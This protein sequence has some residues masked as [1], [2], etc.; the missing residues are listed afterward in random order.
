MRY[1]MWK[2]QIPGYSQEVWSSDIY[3]QSLILVW[4]QKTVLSYKVSKKRP[5]QKTQRPLW[6]GRVVQTPQSEMEMA[7]VRPHSRELVFFCEFPTCED[8]SQ[9]TLSASLQ[10][11]GRELCMLQIFKNIKLILLFNSIVCGVKLIKCGNKPR[12]IN[13]M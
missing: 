12:W 2:W 4:V 9:D 3:D 6:C 5:G 11:V 1:S 10:T 7:C 8:T 13:F